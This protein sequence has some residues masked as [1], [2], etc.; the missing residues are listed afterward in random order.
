M[1]LVSRWTLRVS[2]IAITF[3]YVDFVVIHCT[4]RYN[5]ILLKSGPTFQSQ[6]YTCVFYSA[7]LATVQ[8]NHSWPKVKIQGDILPTSVDIGTAQ[9]LFQN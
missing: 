5:G 8:N 2:I 3:V 6:K 9:F 7:R 1:R 4:R